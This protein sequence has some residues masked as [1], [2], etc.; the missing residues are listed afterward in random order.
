MWSPTISSDE[1]YH[2]GILGMRWGKQNGPPY[3]LSSDISTG[4]RL[5]KTFVSGSSKTQDRSSGYY[6]KNLPSK[7]R[8][9][10]NAKMK[11][12]NTIL[13]GDAPG[14]DRQTQDYLKKKN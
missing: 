9:E 13:V 1:L 4:S 11:A 7:V 6:R 8:R 12:G 5:K 14:I 2:H 3:P 10:L